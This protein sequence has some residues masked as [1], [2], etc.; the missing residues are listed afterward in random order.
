MDMPKDFTLTKKI[1]LILAIAVVLI[2]AITITNVFR[3]IYVPNVIVENKIDSYLYIPTG[4]SIEDVCQILYQKNFIINRNS[5]EWLAE[6]KKYSLNIKP[7]RYK[8]KNNMSNNELI[9][10]LRSGKQEPVKLSLNNIRTIDQLAGIV[11][12]HLEVDSLAIIHI[13]KNNEVL[14]KYGFNENTIIAVFLPNT[15]DFYWNTSAN[16]FLKHMFKEYSK[17]WN[18]S[19][20]TKAKEIGMSKIQISIIASI[21]NEES[22]KTSEYSAL[23]G[24]YINR[25]KHEMPLQADPTIKFAM[26]DFTIKRILHKYTEINSPYNTYKNL[27]LPPGPI[28][29][30][31]IK[32]ID[33]VLNYDKTNYLYFCAKP[34]FSGYHVFAK[35]LI[36]HNKNA[37]A[38]QKALDQRK[39]Y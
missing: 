22:N 34:D 18:S 38:Y 37:E 39:I 20:Q 24:V 26:G 21:V 5:F 23:A 35:T 28:S 6:K 13:L 11:G 1:L 7:G 8:L 3:K 31:T 14:E 30:P 27:G 4:S 17:F 36:Q 25:L 16:E 9:N 29:M 33:A 12:H 15:Y 32:A 2:I 10:L 19:R